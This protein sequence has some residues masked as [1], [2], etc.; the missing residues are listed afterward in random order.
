[1]Q[2]ASGMGTVGGKAAY[3]A[4]L[5]VGTTI[6]GAVAQTI[7]DLVQ[8]KNPRGYFG[9]DYV[10]RN[11][12]SAFLKGGSLGLYGDFLF[13][14]T[15]QASKNGPVASLLGPVAG[16]VEETFNLTQGNIVQAMQGKET[17]FGA[18]LTRFARNNLPGANLWYAKAALDHMIFH[19]LQEYF[20][21]GYLSRM[22][23]RARDEFGQTYFWKPGAGMDEMN[24]PDLSKAFGE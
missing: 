1:M 22:E 11:W 3:L 24:A 10:G 23:K 7:S 2:R 5:V 18:E 20:S 16:L 19:Q 21:P 17:H 6:L 9:G 8:G 12:L 14:G 15:T 4:S 13:S